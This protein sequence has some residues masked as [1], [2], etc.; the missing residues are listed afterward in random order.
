MER[1]NFSY[2]NNNQLK[3]MNQ[4]GQGWKNKQSKK[5]NCNKYYKNDSNKN[6]NNNMEEK[7]TTPDKTKKIFTI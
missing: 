5:N 3:D 6:K 4:S 2:Y 7:S 1:P